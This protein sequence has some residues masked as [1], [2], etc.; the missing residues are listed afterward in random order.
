MK[1]AFLI[2]GS[3]ADK[4]EEAAQVLAAA[5]GQYGHRLINYG[6]YGKDSFLMTTITNSILASAL[7]ACGAADFIISGCGSGVG[8]NICYNSMPN[9][10][11][12]LAEEPYEVAEGVKAIRCNCLSFPFG[13][14]FGVGGI[15]NLRFTAELMFESLGRMAEDSDA[16]KEYKKLKAL[17]CKDIRTII[18]SE[19]IGIVRQAFGGPH[20]MEYL[21]RDCTDGGSLAAYIHHIIDAHAEEDI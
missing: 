21:E 17:C 16:L 11:S 12:M 15:E 5:A 1:I 18:A 10:V 9:I 20:V 14:R 8:A 6:Q 2:D 4:N 3:Q 19:E 13:K 7:L